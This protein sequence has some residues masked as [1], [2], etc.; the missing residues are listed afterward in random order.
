MTLDGGLV[1]SVGQLAREQHASRSAFTREALRD[2]PE[3]HRLRQLEQR[4][5]HGY[6]EKSVA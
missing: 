1:E 4:H 2:V 5:G 6:T 3:K